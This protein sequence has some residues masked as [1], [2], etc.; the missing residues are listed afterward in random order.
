MTEFTVPLDEENVLGCRS[1]AKS[2]HVQTGYEACAIAIVRVLIRNYRYVR[3]VCVCM[4]EACFE[5]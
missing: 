1:K 5:K 4:Y 2:E 3:C